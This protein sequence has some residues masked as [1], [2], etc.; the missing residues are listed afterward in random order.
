MQVALIAFSLVVFVVATPVPSYHDYNTPS[1]PEYKEKE[2]HHA[3]ANYNFKYDAVDHYAN[4]G[5][6]ESRKGDFTKGSYYVDL[7]DGR[8]QH[9]NYYVDGH[10]GYVAEVTYEGEINYYNDYKSPYYYKSH[11]QTYQY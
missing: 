9:V 8:R 5:H 10:S 1:Y 2:H 4:F 7:P 11:K 3:L 6:E